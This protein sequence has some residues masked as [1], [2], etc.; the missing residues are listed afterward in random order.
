MDLKGKIFGPKVYFVE[1]FYSRFVTV[2]LSRECL[3]QL[4]E[5]YTKQTPPTHDVMFT[6]LVTPSTQYFAHIN[7]YFVDLHGSFLQTHGIEGL[8]KIFNYANG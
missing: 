7:V 3:A 4:D 1:L 6:L 2:D 8:V 5:Y